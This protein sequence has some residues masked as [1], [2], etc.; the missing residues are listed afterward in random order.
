MRD[1][2]LCDLL[3]SKA[4]IGYDSKSGTAEQ[5]SQFCKRTGL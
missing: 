4:G 2:S 1:R 3:A 5:F